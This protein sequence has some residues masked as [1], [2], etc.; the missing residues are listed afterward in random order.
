MKTHM[1]FSMAVSFTR[2]LSGFIDLWLTISWNTRK[3]R[4]TFE[5]ELIRE[6]MAKN[7]AKRLGSKYVALKDNIENKESI[8]RHR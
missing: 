3:A 5:K 1:I 4:R 2:I 8:R 7:D 6:G